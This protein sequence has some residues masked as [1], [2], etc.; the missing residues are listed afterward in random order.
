MFRF[1]L[2]YIINAFDKT[3][4][5]VLMVIGIYFMWLGNV[6]PRYLQQR[7]NFAEYGELITELPTFVGWIQYKPGVQSS[8]HLEFGEDYSIV[9]W[10]HPWWKQTV[11]KEGDN[12]MEKVGLRLELKP[13][14]NWD[15]KF[16]ITPLNFSTDLLD[17]EFRLTFRFVNQK[18]LLVSGVKIALS[19]NNNSNCAWGWDNYDGDVTH[20][21]AQPGQHLKT[22]IKPEKYIFSPDGGECRDKPFND[23]EVE[24]LTEY[25]KL[26]CPRPC[27]RENYWICNK[28][29]ESPLPLCYDGE[30]TQCFLT[31]ENIKNKETR[32]GV[33]AKV[34]GIL[35]KPCTKVQ[36]KTVEDS[37]THTEDQVELV[38]YFTKPAMLTVHEEYLIYDLVAFISSVGGTFGLCIGFSFLDVGKWLIYFLEVLLS[39]GNHQS[40]FEERKIKSKTKINEN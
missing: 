37:Y 3:L 1:K 29:L 14:Y 26:N 34:N 7:T 10:N 9:Y 31:A 4:Y 13:D 8:E 2:K 11:L 23:I 5:I 16:K 38:F 36:Y 40:G 12:W 21:F 19:S 17:I 25:M 39:K 33:V 30:E 15:K 35:I 32:N 28:R 18:H 27:R 22:L 6:W 24:R 20:V